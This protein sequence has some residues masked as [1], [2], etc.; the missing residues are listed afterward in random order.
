M[1]SLERERERGELRLL[2]H[3]TLC[4]RCPECPI[5]KP[6]FFSFFFLNVCPWPLSRK[7]HLTTSY[8]SSTNKMTWLPWRGHP[9]HALMETQPRT[10]TPQTGT[11]QAD[12]QWEK[13]H[14]DLIPISKGGGGLQLSAELAALIWHLVHFKRQCEFAYLCLIAVLFLY[15]TVL[16]AVS[17]HLRTQLCCYGK[18]KK[19][20]NSRLWWGALFLC[21]SLFTLF[22]HGSI[23]FPFP[24]P[25]YRMY[26]FTW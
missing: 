19:K 18:N 16:A 12:T 4:P 21:H 5:S 6:I 2:E 7:K 22:C 20:S 1:P 26:N 10:G 24:T 15:F 25:F 11:P 9:W 13:Y 8:N 3:L 14:R 23:V 17:H